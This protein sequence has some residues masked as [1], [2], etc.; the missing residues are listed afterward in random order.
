MSKGLLA[1][2]GAALAVCTVDVTDA[3]A[4]SR[5]NRGC[6]SYYAPPVAYQYGPPPGC[7]AGCGPGYPGYGQGYGQGYGLGYGYVPPA[8]VYGYGPPSRAYYA[9]PPYAAPVYGYGAGQYGRG[10]RGCDRGYGYAPRAVYY[11]D[12][13]Y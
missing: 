1:G 11:G 10:P 5:R 4:C 9:P 7:R 3:S 6:G 13:D 12:D 2:L 8:P